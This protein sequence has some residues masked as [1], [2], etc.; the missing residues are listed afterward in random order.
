MRAVRVA[1]TVDS[2]VHRG[3]GGAHLRLVAVRASQRGDLK[4]HHAQ[5]GRREVRQHTKIPADIAHR[6]LVLAEGL[7]AGV[8]R[9]TAD[10]EPLRSLH[11]ELQ[12]ERLRRPT[13]KRRQEAYEVVLPN[14][15][16]N[17]L[18]DSLGKVG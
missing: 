10:F 17:V 8:D 18:P 6:E 3:R 7:L 1:H 12:R 4:R 13:M 9:N 14:T 16:W 5:R 11:A 15:C 2:V